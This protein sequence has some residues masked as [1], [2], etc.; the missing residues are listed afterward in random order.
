MAIQP[1]S[2]LSI[3]D[4]ILER[5]DDFAHRLRPMTTDLTVITSNYATKEDARFIH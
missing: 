3:T 1:K 5:L 4:H 2:G